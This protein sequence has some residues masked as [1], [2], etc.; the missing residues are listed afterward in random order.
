MSPLLAAQLNPGSLH[1]P[2]VCCRSSSGRS[3]AGRERGCSLRWE[4]ERVLRAP[5]QPGLLFL[6]L[7]RSDK[8]SLQTR[9]KVHFSQRSRPR[10]PLSLSSDQNEQLILTKVLLLLGLVQPSDFTQGSKC[11]PEKPPCDC[12]DLSCGQG[13]HLCSAEEV[14]L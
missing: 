5:L 1:W 13:C 14:A 4:R 12:Q 7:P 11:L 9:Y 10:T 3:F 2:C 8:V 6:K